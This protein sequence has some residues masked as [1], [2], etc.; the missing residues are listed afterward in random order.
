MSRSLNAMIGSGPIMEVGMPAPTASA[1]RFELTS[2]LPTRRLS[3]PVRWAE[4]GS[5]SSSSSIAAKC[6]RLGAGS[7]V[8]WIAASLPALHS[9]TSGAIAGCMPKNPSVATS[10]PGWMPMPGRAW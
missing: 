2:S 8:A 7:P 9:G 6:E 1:C 5:A 4:P 3:H 10:A